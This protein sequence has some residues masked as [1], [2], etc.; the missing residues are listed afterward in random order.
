MQEYIGTKQVKA[1]PMSRG[2]YNDY[3]AW[4]LPSNEDGTDEGYLVEY[5]DGGKPNDH[6]HNGYISWS[7]K[8]QFEGAYQ[9]SGELSFGH[10]TVLAEAGYK[11][12][13]KGWNGAGMFAYIVP[14]DS[15]PA[16]TEV[17]KGTFEGDMVP[18]RAYWALKTAQDDVAMWAP[19][20]SDTLAKDWT[21]VE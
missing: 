3:R 21:I 20:G 16:Q 11:V 17:I 14:A 13:R 7:P 4:P 2:D 5:T 9:K 19:S 18:Y 1:T 15:Y 6:R 10:A 8:E 12:A